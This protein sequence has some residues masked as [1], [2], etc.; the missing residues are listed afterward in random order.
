MTPTYTQDQTAEELEQGWRDPGKGAPVPL[1]ED[2]APRRPDREPNGKRSASMPEG[3][4]QLPASLG[5][6]IADDSRYIRFQIPVPDARQ[7]GSRLR[8][9]FGVLTQ[10]K[11]SRSAADWLEA[12]A[13]LKEEAVRL[14]ETQYARH[15]SVLLALA[16]GLTFTDP[17]DATAEI[18]TGTFDRALALLSEPFLA[19][20]EEEDFLVDLLAH[21]WNLAP[22][23]DD[24][25]LGG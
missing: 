24:A 5:E 16:D 8:R 11:S 20:P 23:A 25:S 6:A 2:T 22:S 4:T 3:A 13:I 19:E 21:G 1:A 14:R 10:I 7:A 17:S 12:A 15:S 9:S 18:Q